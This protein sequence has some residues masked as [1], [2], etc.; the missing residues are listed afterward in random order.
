MGICQFN[1]IL[2][3]NLNLY[4]GTW[5]VKSALS[6]TALL[7]VLTTLPGGKSVIVI[8]LLWSLPS[9]FAR[10]LLKQLHQH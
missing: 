9:S 6:P 1:H 8:V 10:I 7:V 4:L 3:L 5:R 2:D